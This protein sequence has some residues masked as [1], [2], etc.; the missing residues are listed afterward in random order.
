MN[1]AIVLT[2]RLDLPAAQGLLT[3]L[4]NAQ[5]DDIVLD[6]GDVTYLGA[7]CLQVLI[8]AADASRSNGH[9]FSLINTSDRVLDQLR[10]MGMTPQDIVKGR[11]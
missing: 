6:M 10:V 8:A 3:V 5:D 1:D 7:L 4:T 11:Q 2:P 9:G